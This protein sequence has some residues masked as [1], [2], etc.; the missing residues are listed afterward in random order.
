MRTCVGRKTVS[1]T[2]SVIAIGRGVAVLSVATWKGRGLVHVVT[3][4]KNGWK[5]LETSQLVNSVILHSALIENI[6]PCHVGLGRDERKAVVHSPYPC[7]R[8]NLVKSNVRSWYFTT[9]SVSVER[10][11][12][13]GERT[14]ILDFSVLL[15]FIDP[16]RFLC[17]VPTCRL[18]NTLCRV[19]KLC[20]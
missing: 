12:G 1:L 7:G 2:V 17:D 11:M 13:E 3:Q 19:Y 18:L 15:S 9:N 6:K 5:S 16:I 14:C 8:N 10:D 4:D 20:K